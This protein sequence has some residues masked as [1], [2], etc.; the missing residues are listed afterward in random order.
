MRNR[1]DKGT[2]KRGHAVEHYTR[3]AEE[4]GFSRGPYRTPDDR[5]TPGGQHM[6]LQPLSLFIMSL[7]ALVLVCAVQLWRM[8]T[9]DSVFGARSAVVEKGSKRWLLGGH[10]RRVR[11]D[12][13]AAPAKPEAAFDDDPPPPPSAPQPQ[14]DAVPEPLG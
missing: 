2:G 7:I 6:L 9:F 11:D 3:L 8:G 10:A 12:R 4:F 5:R 14:E 1:S 13:K